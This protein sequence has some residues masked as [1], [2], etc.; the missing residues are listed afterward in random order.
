MARPK[1][2]VEETTMTEEFL[3]AVKQL[4]R[5]IGNATDDA[6]HDTAQSVDLELTAWIEKGYKLF[7]THFVGM[8]GMNVGLVYILVLA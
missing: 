4:V 7:N 2:I 1:K 6:G 5:W 8:D 3:P